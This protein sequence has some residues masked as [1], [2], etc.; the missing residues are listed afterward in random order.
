MDKTGW[1]VTSGIVALVAVAAGFA[2]HDNRMVAQQAV[3]DLRHLEATRAQVVSV[4]RVVQG[5]RRPTSSTG[6][7]PTHLALDAEA[8]R[9]YSAPP[10]A[11]SPLRITGALSVATSNCPRREVHRCGPG[12]PVGVV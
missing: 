12:V 7:A 3:A 11:G 10:A 2:A 9:R 1:Q 4:E 5:V 6:A 8:L